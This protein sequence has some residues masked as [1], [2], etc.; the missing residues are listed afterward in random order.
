[1]RVGPAVVG[2]PP[3]APTGTALKTM[4]V[5]R[6]PAATHTQFLAVLGMRIPSL[7]ARVEHPGL[8]HVNAPQTCCKEVAAAQMR[9]PL[10]PEAG[11]T[12]VPCR[13]LLAN[14]RHAGDWSRTSCASG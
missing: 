14:H 9:G 13:R 10:V 6:L 5:T 1:L 11:S 4:S 7:S 8:P 3:W 2:R 12:R